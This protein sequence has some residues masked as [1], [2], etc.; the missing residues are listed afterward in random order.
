MMLTPS[1]YNVVIGG[2]S[3]AIVWNT[4]TR[5]LRVFPST[6][7]ILEFIESAFVSER[8]EQILLS[9]E[10]PDYL[11]ALI[12]K[13]QGFL[14]G[15]D[16][17]LKESMG[18]V[19]I[20]RPQEDFFNIVITTTLGCNFNCSYC[21][22]GTDKE[23]EFIPEAMI[24]HITQMID[25]T[26]LQKIKITWYGGEPLLNP[27]LVI[28]ASNHIKR[29]VETRGGHY[30]GEMYTNG[31]LL[32]HRMATKL[33]DAG[34]SHFQ[35]SIDG[36][37]SS[38]DTSRMLRNGSPSYD[39]IMKNI[40]EN[41]QK[42][43]KSLTYTIR[44]NLSSESLEISQVISDLINSGARSWKF[45]RYYLAPIEN[46]MGTSDGNEETLSNLEKFAD[47]YTEF[48]KL[49]DINGLNGIMPYFNQGLCT[50]TRKNSMIVTPSGEIHKCWDTVTTSAE[51]VAEISQI[52]ASLMSK[53]TDNKWTNFDAMLNKNC[54]NCRL[55]P[56]CGGN[57]AIKHYQHYAESEG[58][59]SACPP[60]K[61]LLGEY[62]IRRVEE[63]SQ[64]LPYTP[65]NFAENRKI[66]VKDLHVSM[67]SVV[68][69]S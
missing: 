1:R 32:T 47:V 19:E 57:C 65:N 2:S 24:S 43:S 59:H 53:I 41:W 10:S 50:A 29:H 52:N 58:F 64:D 3:H 55:L 46:R 62:L 22:Q 51:S 36:S 11:E 63:C 25:S 20:K 12:A 68:T 18:E 56:V 69:N 17:Y 54:R 9:E 37:K 38:H 61:F 35:I 40:N 13:Q 45:A 28:N 14:V 48:L 30:K 16:E 4:K 7:K 6:S 21:C 23:F 15:N 67:K 27:Q 66:S 39:Q 31:Y 26:S 44:I 49:A 8:Y 60:L 5:S 42:N 34:I 33:A